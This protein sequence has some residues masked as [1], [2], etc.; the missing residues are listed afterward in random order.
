VHYVRV[1]TESELAD[2]LARPGAS[3]LSGGTDLLVKIRSGLVSPTALVDLS[4]IESLQGIAERD[5]EVLIGAATSEAEILESPIVAERAPLLSQVLRSLGSVQIRHRGTLGGNLANASPAA[6]GAIPLLLYD[7]RLRIAGKDGERTVDLDRFF[8]GPGRTVL[9]QGE[10]I[11]S[12]LIPALGPASHDD[13]SV[14]FHKVGK[15]R[16]L[17][18][19]IAS[20]GSLLRVEAETIDVRIAVGSVAPTPIRLRIV[21]RRLRGAHLA[22]ALIAEACT[23]ASKEVSPIDDVRATAAYRRRVVAGLLARSLETARVS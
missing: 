6:D 7:A 15:R 9:A 20:L 3:P 23:E 12:I 19:S 4:R 8:V 18:I 10:Y 2:A 5:G 14:F 17:T 22:G 16:A 13:W 1:K 21:E 11:R